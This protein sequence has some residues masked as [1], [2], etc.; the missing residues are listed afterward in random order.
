[1][2]PYTPSYSNADL[3]IVITPNYFEVF[4][5]KSVCNIFFEYSSQKRPDCEAIREDGDGESALRRKKTAAV[6]LQCITL[7]SHVCNQQV[8]KPLF[9][10]FVF[11]ISAVICLLRSVRLPVCLCKTEGE[12]ALVSDSLFRL[13]LYLLD[14]PFVMLHWCL[15]SVCL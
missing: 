1:M 13:L 6:A 2:K 4:K 8:Q 3:N 5:I 9:I 15:S 10:M 12:G 11:V 14:H 7:V